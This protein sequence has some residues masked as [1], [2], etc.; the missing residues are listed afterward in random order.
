MQKNVVYQSVSSILVYF[1]NVSSVV[2]FK[3]RLP[4][5]GAM[6]LASDYIHCFYT[7]VI[8]DSCVLRPLTLAMDLPFIHMVHASLHK[9]HVTSLM[10][11]C[12]LQDQI[13]LAMSGSQQHYC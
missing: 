10:V 12:T 11:Q 4:Y 1:L 7:I 8:Y 13:L 9:V 2:M 6:L 5:F 3:N